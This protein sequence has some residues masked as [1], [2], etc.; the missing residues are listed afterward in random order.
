MKPLQS[1][2]TPFNELES[3]LK[4]FFDNKFWKVR[5]LFLALA[6]STTTLLAFNFILVDKG[7]RNLYQE[8]RHPGSIGGFFW[9]DIIKQ[10]ADPFT[11]QDYEAGSHEANQTFRI[12]IPLIARV[13]HLNVA[14]LYVLHVLMGL[15]F[16]WFVIE[17]VYGILKDKI[18]TFYFITG[19]T[20]IYAGANFYINF[21]GHCDIFPFCFMILMWYYRNP[22]LILLFSQLAFWC[23]ERAIINST[24]IGL[25]YLMPL[26]QN[27]IKQGK[28]NL[29]L[30]PLSAIVLV[31]SAGLYI[32]VRS[33]LAS[34]YGLKVGHDNDLS[35]KTITWSLSI[36]GD[37]FTRGLEGF[38]LLIFAGI[39]VLVLRRDWWMLVLLGGCMLATGA[40][41]IMVA[42]GTR[43]LSFGFCMFFFL[44]IIL[45][46]HIAQ[47]ELRYLLIVSTLLSLMLPMSFP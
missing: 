12:T 29:K 6:I 40:I 43:S 32:V 17:V 7:L 10:G 46:E 31:I 36:I 14:G 16:L 15:L 38:W 13:L 30:I 4:P 37:K 26:V 2:A 45:K 25:L 5:L 35:R 47:K 22:L 33:W 9:D 24:Y 28:L 11:P 42:D 27:W 41:A 18:L 20:A 3:K 19:F 23:D 8:M 34:N 21:L 1:L 44:L 39:T